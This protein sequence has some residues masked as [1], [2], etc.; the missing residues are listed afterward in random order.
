MSVHLMFFPPQQLQHH[1]NYKLLNYSSPRSLKF[2]S[3]L[4]KTCVLCYFRGCLRWKSFHI[5]KLW[6]LYT[7][8]PYIAI[9]L[10]FNFCIYLWKIQSPKFHIQIEL[11]TVLLREKVFCEIKKETVH[12]LFHTPSVVSPS[13]MA[14]SR[15]I[16]CIKCFL[17]KK[18]KKREG[19]VI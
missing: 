6:F 15:H 10:V 19:N 3:I 8:L 1:K 2:Q 5:K 12:R 9:S 16:K 11:N 4:K 13:P 14:T 7:C 18:K 17:K